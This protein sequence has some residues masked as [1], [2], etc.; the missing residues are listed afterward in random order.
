MRQTLLV[1]S[2]HPMFHG[3]PTVHFFSRP[4][5]SSGVAS[6]YATIRKSDGSV[7]RFDYDSLLEYN[8]HKAV[9]NAKLSAHHAK[10]GKRL[11]CNCG[12]CRMA[13]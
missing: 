5:L 6:Y 4:F 8:Q 7:Y 10:S 13:V 3:K 11:G 9:I 12:H 2:T 1:S